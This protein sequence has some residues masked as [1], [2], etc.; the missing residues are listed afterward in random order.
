MVMAAD[1][2]YTQSVV[3]NILL[4]ALQLQAC[5]RPG[6]NTS[7]NSYLRSSVSWYIVVS[8]V[9]SLV[10]GLCCSIFILIETS[11]PRCYNV[12]DLNF[13]QH[14]R[15]KIHYAEVADMRMA[16]ENQGNDKFEPHR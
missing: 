9:S 13:T 1:T 5:S 16:S 15:H 10:S 6:H 7:Y 8:A 12:D 11:S 14:T 3:I 4:D 2:Y